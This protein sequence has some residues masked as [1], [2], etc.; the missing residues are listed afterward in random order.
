MAPA[1]SGPWGPRRTQAARS[2]AQSYNPL[3]IA[4]PTKRQ[5][6]WEIQSRTKKKTRTSGELVFAFCGSA[7]VLV[8]LRSVYLQAQCRLSLSKHL[9]SLCRA[10]V[11]SREADN[12]VAKVAPPSGPWFLAPA[13]TPT[14]ALF[15]HPLLSKFHLPRRPLSNPAFCTRS[16]ESPEWVCIFSSSQSHRPS[17]V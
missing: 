1:W 6:V 14:W 9:S 5:D 12:P 4:P 7:Y 13:T 16:S 15:L 11:P 17:Y 2:R 10:W 8:D 3:L